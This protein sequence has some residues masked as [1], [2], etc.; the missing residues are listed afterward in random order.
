M[1]ILKWVGGKGQMLD[2]I[3]EHV[4]NEI[5]VYREPFLGGGAVLLEVLRKC[6]AGEMRVD[7][8]EVGDCN[9]HLVSM[10]EAVR[11]RPTELKEELETMRDEYT[12]APRCGGRERPMPYWTCRTRNLVSLRARRTTIITCG[13]V[14]TRSPPR[15]GLCF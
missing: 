15:P 4:P 11:D 14:L 5:R 3:M 13:S 6:R 8:F 1:P 12:R 9:R 10:Y 2:R 7:R